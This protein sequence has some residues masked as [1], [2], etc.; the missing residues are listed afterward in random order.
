M[1]LFQTQKEESL[2]KIC[3]FL[4]YSR[5]SERY[6]LYDLQPHKILISRDVKFDELSNW[7]WD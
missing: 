5:D 1:F 2:V 4:G 6:R 3:I 7:N